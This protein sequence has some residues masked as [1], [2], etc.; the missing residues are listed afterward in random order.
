MKQLDKG[1]TVK[2]RFTP[3]QANPF[4]VITREQGRNLQFAD[5]VLAEVA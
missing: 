5:R 4:D 2:S 1:L 3:V